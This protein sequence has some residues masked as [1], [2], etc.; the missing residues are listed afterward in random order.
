MSEV[1]NV[2]LVGFGMSGKLFH[3]PFIDANRNFELKKVVERNN[4]NSIKYYPYV[5]IINS[6]DELL[7]DKEIKLIV[8]TTPNIFHYEQAKKALLAGKHI[9][10]E[11]PFTPTS[12]EA[13]ELI[14]LSH[15]QNRQIFVFQNRRWDGDFLTIKKILKSNLLGKLL[16]YEAHFD[17]YTPDL[18]IKPWREANDPAGGNLY[19]LGTHLIDQA[20]CLFGLPKSVWA[21]IRT[22]RKGSKVDDAFEVI[23]NYPELKITLKAGML[24]RE[25]GPRYILNGTKGS[26]VKYGIDPQEDDLDKGFSPD[27]EGWG[28]DF[29]EKYGFLNTEIDG[30]VFKGNI[31]TIPGSYQKFYENVYDVLV[32]NIEAAIKPEEARDVIRIIELA[33]KSNQLGKVLPL[34][35]YLQSKQDTK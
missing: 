17:R 24:L 1:I 22:Q 3:A 26:F 10:I 28:E 20:V 18:N 2:G 11:K 19:D 13:Q 21:D 34:L 12:K 4:R 29:P 14:D 30:L 6:Y 23:L 31:K 33:F 27:N 7:L 16:E 35:S 5:E 8:I 9:V 25:E 32:N 15:K